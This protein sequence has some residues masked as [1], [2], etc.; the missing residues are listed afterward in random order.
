M[1]E[2]QELIRNFDK[3]RDYMRDFYIYGF[4]SRSDFT[5]KSARTYDNEKRR[6]ESYIGEYMKWEYTKS[7]K[8]LFISMDCSKVPVNPL[9]AAWKSKAF[10]NND[11]MLHFYILDALKNKEIFSIDKLTDVICK[12]SDQIFDIQT[13]R[14]KC[15]EYH[16]L[17]LIA[18]KKQGKSLYY[19][20]SPDNFEHMLTMAPGLSDAVKFFQ[21]ATAFGEI[22][23]FIMDN[24]NTLNGLFSFKHYYAAHTLED[25]ILLDLLSAIRNGQAIEFL[26]YNESGTRISTLDG[27][28]LKIF[29][30][31]ATGRRYLCVYK[32][33]TKR[34]F[35]YRLDHIKAV[36]TLGFCNDTKKHYENLMKNLPNI[37]GV[38]FGG[39]SR[40]EIVC[41]KLSINEETE[42]YILER[43][44]REG[45]D[46]ELIRLEPNVFLY[47][48]E[49]FDSNDISP[50]L[51]TFT[52][53]II[54]LE[55]TNQIVIDR[56]YKD[57]KRMKE[58]Y[59][60]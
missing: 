16:T 12:R 24:Q 27:I 19:S 42:A 59:G 30:S 21:G 49:M 45:H 28:P 14:N 52:G 10:T 47:T 25:A 23:S 55:G 8:N 53:R 50:W 2:F 40:M 20:L 32:T 35:N 38:G 33:R 31:A 56:F 46:G 44:V 37:W 17:G 34:F 58:M 57:I 11:I 4:K 18:A 7:G 13:V 22:G 9:Y 6:I 51:K 54:Q 41:M 26:N 36:K 1:G 15:N 39:E 43:I 3:I 29:I 5:H 60:N 48:K